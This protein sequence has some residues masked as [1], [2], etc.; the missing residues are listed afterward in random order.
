LIDQL[1]QYPIKIN[2]IDE[3]LEVQINY[4]KEEVEMR[5]ESLKI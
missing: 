2:E 1:S 3:H 4:W 5:A